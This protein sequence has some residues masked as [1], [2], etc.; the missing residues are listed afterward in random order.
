MH[1]VAEHFTEVIARPLLPGFPAAA[2]A[3]AISLTSSSATNNM[4]T[5]A[6][7]SH[8]TNNREFVDLLAIFRDCSI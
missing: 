6:R 3:Y 8:N 2:R 5:V 4:A 7:V 1:P